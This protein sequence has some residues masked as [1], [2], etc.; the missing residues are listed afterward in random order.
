M[1]CRKGRG[2]IQHFEGERNQRFLKGSARDEV[3]KKLEHDLPS[4]VHRKFYASA[5]EKKLECGNL[6][7]VKNL[8]VLQQARFEVGYSKV[9]YF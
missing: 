5:D 6:D 3:K 1:F 9:Q 2:S 4:N 8:R 7:D